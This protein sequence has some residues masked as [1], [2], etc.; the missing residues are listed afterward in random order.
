[1]N[2]FPGR[3]QQLPT[4]SA[5]SAQLPS[6]PAHA[7][8]AAAQPAA[9]PQ[10][11]QSATDLSAKP[12][13]GPA[14]IQAQSAAHAYPL[15]AVLAQ[16]SASPQIQSPAQDGDALKHSSL[17]PAGKQTPLEPALRLIC[18]Q[19]TQAARQENDS[20]TPPVPGAAVLAGSQKHGLETEF[21]PEAAM[22]AGSQ[23]PSLRTCQGHSQSQIPPGQHR[24]PSILQDLRN[25]A[26][27]DY[28]HQPPDPPSPCAAVSSQ[29]APLEPIQPRQ[30]ALPE[31]QSS[32]ETT[33]MQVPR[34]S[35]ASQ[36]A[37]TF[38]L[39]LQ[40]AAKPHAHQP[41]SHLQTPAAELS[42]A[43]DAMPADQGTS[44]GSGPVRKLAVADQRLV[45]DNIAA[46][47]H[48]KGRS[49]TA[50]VIEAEVSALPDKQPV[51]RSQRLSEKKA[52]AAQAAAEVAAQ[53]AAQA[54]A[55]VAQAAVLEA[56]GKQ[57]KLDLASRVEAVTST[58]P[59]VLAECLASKRSKRV[60]G[61]DP[62]EVIPLP[63][64]PLLALPSQPHSRVIW[65]VLCA[66]PKHLG[67]SITSI[68]GSISWLLSHEAATFLWPTN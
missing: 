21:G 2:V 27:Q 34:L 62:L 66:V 59:L 48:P 19:N 11:L 14:Q 37:V 52:A 51:V 45:S 25:A 49:T 24:T 67:S 8:C 56:A 33:S 39:A 61:G 13:V 6:A 10:H 32:Q 17:S 29:Q 50:A 64:P 23:D 22:L 31:L 26:A 12:H 5:A 9:P 43:S 68:P 28:V 1:M 30:Q 63:P 35:T 3:A 18:Q 4:H 46:A 16:M 40:E 44:A 20:L 60:P 36:S 47:Q 53:A 58:V 15:A 41:C 38:P 57:T 65:I 55:A 42:L 54:V 7:S